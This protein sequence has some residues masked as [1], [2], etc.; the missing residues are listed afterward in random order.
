ME[1]QHAAGIVVSLG[2]FY[3]AVVMLTMSTKAGRQWCLDQPEER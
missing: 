3:D 2:W 1:R